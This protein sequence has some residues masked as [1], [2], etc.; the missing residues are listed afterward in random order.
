ME[1]LKAAV[2]IQNKRSFDV[3]EYCKM[4]C[5]EQKTPQMKG[6]CRLL[7]RENLC[8]RKSFFP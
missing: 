8:D 7:Q 1:V 4:L 2:K 3:C 6:K 5:H